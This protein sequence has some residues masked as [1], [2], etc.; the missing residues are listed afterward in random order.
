[1]NTKRIVIGGVIAI[2]ALTVI[3]PSVMTPQSMTTQPE[4]AAVER[5]PENGPFAQSLIEAE[6]EKIVALLAKPVLKAP[7]VATGYIP[8]TSPVPANA[9]D[10]V[11][12]KWVDGDTLDVEING[13]VDRVRVLGI[14]A[15]ERGTK[16]GDRITREVKK[17]YPRDMAVQLATDPKQ[18]KVD[19]Y[20][21][22][23]RHVWIAGQLYA[24][25]ALWGEPSVEMTHKRF[26]KTS[27]HEVLV[28]AK[29]AFDWLKPENLENY[30]SGADHP[31]CAEH[32]AAG[33]GPF[34]DAGELAEH[35]DGDNDGQV[36]E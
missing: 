15:P 10:A 8:P 16:A 18:D 30:P 24:A 14:D 21:R 6:N 23:L 32:N 13:K 19:R 34:T 4:A 7:T 9:V 11:I 1:M 20:G 36:C 26:G 35:R 3:A 25:E 33:E 31:T 12:V 5:M 29:T 28:E 27:Y 22:L 17:S 2:A